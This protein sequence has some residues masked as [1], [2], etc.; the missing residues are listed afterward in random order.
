MYDQTKICIKPHI[1]FS[2]LSNDPANI[3]S[4]YHVAFCHFS[5]TVKDKSNKNPNTDPMISSFGIINKR[6]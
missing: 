6:Q 4:Y 5:I 3:I 2:W 1:V